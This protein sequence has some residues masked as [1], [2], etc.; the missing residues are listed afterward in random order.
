[1]LLG[2]GRNIAHTL[3]TSRA[4]VPSY[5]IAAYLLSKEG[6]SHFSDI[7]Q[8]PISVDFYT[9]F[10]QIVRTTTHRVFQT[11]YQLSV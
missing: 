9:V 2:T 11:A 10:M 1:M 7:S 5:D 4:Q 8:E 6:N 3:K